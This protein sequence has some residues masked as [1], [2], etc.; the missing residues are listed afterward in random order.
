MTGGMTYT[1]SHTNVC[2]FAIFIQFYVNSFKS[3][4]AILEKGLLE[5][6]ST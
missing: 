6:S 5:E 2:K 1:P 4:A 3:V